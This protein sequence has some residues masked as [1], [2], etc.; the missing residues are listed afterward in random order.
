ED[1]YDDDDDDDSLFPTI[2]PIIPLMPFDL[3]P[4]CPFGCQCYV[5]VVH[6]SD[7]G[8]TSIP[9]N[10]PPDTRMIDLQNNKI[11]EVK[12]NDLQGLT[13][14]Y[15][16]ALNNNKISKIH[17]KAFQPTKKL[18]RLYLSHNQL[19]EIPTNLPRTL[20][21]LRI[22]ANKVNKIPKDIFKGMKS[23]H[24]LEISANPINNNGIEPGAFEGVNIY[25]IRIAEAKLTSVPK[26]FPSSLLELHLDDNKI[27]AIEL[28]DFKRYKD[29]QR[30]GLGNN[31]IKE[32]EN[33]SF[34]NMPSIREIH[35][36][37][38]KLKKVPP[39]LPE[40]K[41]LQVVFLHSN[42]IAKLGVND[43]CPTGRRKKK[44]LYSGISLFNNPVKE[45]FC[46]PSFPL[47]MYCDH[48]KLKTI[49]NIPRH[50]QQLYLQN[51]DIEAVPARP[52]TNATFLREINL[53]H[54]RIKFHMIDQGVFAKLSNLVQLHLQHNELEEF[55][56]PL[57]RSLERLLLGFNKISRL[58]G[59]ALEGI[60]NL[61][62]LDLCSNFLEDSALKGKSFSNMKNLMQLNLCNNKLQTMPPDLPSSL[63]YLSL[64]NNSISYIPENYFNRLP[65]II[66]LR[67]SHNNLQDIPPKTFN[68]PNLLE[69]NL[70][71]NKLKQVFYIPRS[72]QHLYIEDN[73]IEK[74]YEEEDD[75]DHETE[76]DREAE[77]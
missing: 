31:R 21:E 43:F 63:M 62:M 73:D 18:R 22:H 29:L 60:P 53:S 76:E 25:H 35:L 41:Y 72:L 69:L 49:P 57:P 33:G 54:N 71:H 74:E 44:A 46:P 50:V 38:N 30:L 37:K 40:L 6:C 59:N 68:L 1:D 19:T 47:S 10:I 52:F 55:P 11:K 77:D 28:E 45:C 65:K 56:F 32:V 34:A 58:S 13:S 27:T 67:M 66:A 70:G 51:N 61:T 5:R 2:E 17:P 12:E 23:L 24:V 14:L 39:G 3:F 16:L 9:R 8:L 64:E 42:H 4:T 48:R 36:E 75:H 20:A 15:A 26:D 7:L